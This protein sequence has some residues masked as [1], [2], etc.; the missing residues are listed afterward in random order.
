MELLQQLGIDWRLL[1]AQIVNFL[2]LLGVLYKLLYRPVLSRLEARTARIEK[3]LAEA[4]RIE[5][6]AKKADEARLQ[7]VAQARK[8]TQAIVEQ[9]A[10][11]AAA[12]RAKM[13]SEARREAERIV[14]SGKVQLEMHKETLLK[15]ARREITGLVVS[16]AEHVLGDVADEGVDASIAKAA[17]RRVGRA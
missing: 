1:A 17:L 4:K 9:A 14:E 10:K 7:M 2:V 5:A 16:A 12:L 13:T 8:E 6:Q 15:D 11:D 3:S